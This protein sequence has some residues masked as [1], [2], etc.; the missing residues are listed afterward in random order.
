[1]KTDG[2][3]VE[4]CDEVKSY[5]EIARQL[6]YHLVQRAPGQSDSRYQTPGPIPM[7]AETAVEVQHKCIWVST[8]ARHGQQVGYH[9][10]VH[11][12]P[13]QLKHAK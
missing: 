4:V 9:C 3:R 7:I 11:S 5:S 2:K 1:M 6:E 10:A 13:W 8:S 12:D